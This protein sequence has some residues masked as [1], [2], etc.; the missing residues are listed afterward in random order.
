MIP[1]ID[2]L[3]GQERVKQTLNNFLKSEKIPQA[4]LFSGIDGV[5]KD[6]AAIQFAKSIVSNANSS[7]AEKKINSIEQ[8]QEPYLKL[9]FPL[10]RGKNETDSNTPIEKLT[11][12]DIESI[13][14]QIELKAQ[15][16]F[17]HISLPKANN[18]KINSVRDIKQFLSMNYDESGYRFILISDA[19]LMKEE[20][21]NS[22]LK[23]LEEPPEKVIF[24]L[25]SSMISKLKPTILSR[26]WKI[27]FDPLPAEV[28]VSILENN[29]Q[30]EKVIAE[31]VAPFA[32]G[33]VQ[34]ALNLIEMNFHNLKEQ[35]IFILRYSFGRKYDS[36][37]T[38]L[39]SIL[40][41]QNNTNYQIVIELILA[42]LN[43]IQKHKLQIDDFYFKD[44][45]ETLEKFNSKFPD[46]QLLNISSRLEKLSNL[47][48][49]NINPAL[50]SANLIC[51][52]S[53][54]VLNQN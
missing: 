54:V 46:I 39:N 47:P 3:P 14:E 12:D 9:I 23:S 16:P 6:N 43:D 26:C 41:N 19:H 45:I 21:Q 5:G 4:L 13:R 48:Q 28:L 35:I 36:A 1:I 34:S 42:W 18:I 2:N 25:T 50:L 22:L 32:F 30:I 8:L 37:L 53:S 27:N 7:D 40:A 44:H 20:A 31:E 29:F 10:P 15:N 11:E 52:L 38:E 51:E 33:S 24:I 49:Q 17:Y